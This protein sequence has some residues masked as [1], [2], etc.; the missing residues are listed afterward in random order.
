MSLSALPL[1]VPA[2]SA[3]G[4]RDASI[5]VTPIPA[6]LEVNPGEAGEYVIRVRN[7]GSNPVSV[8]LSTNQEATQEC[9]AYSSAIT[10]I[11][12]QIDAGSY[13]EATLNVTLT[14]SAEGTCDTTVTVNANEQVTPPD[15]AGAPAQETATVTT[16]AGDGSGSAFFG[17]DLTVNSADKEQDWAGEDELTYRVDV[18][19]TGQNNETI[20]LSVEENNDPGCTSNSEFIVT[21]SDTSVSLDSEEVET[22]T[23]TVEIPDGQSADQYCWDITGTVTNDPSSEAKDTD[24]F[25]LVVPELKTCSVELSK[26]SLSVNPGSSSS[27]TATFSNTGNVDWTVTIASTGSKASWVSVDGASSRLLRYDDGQG[28]ISVDLDVAPDDSIDAGSEAVITILGKDGSS[29]DPDCQKQLRV[30]VGQSYGAS[31]SLATTLLN[32]IDPGTNRSTVVTVSNQGNGQDNLRISS[33]SAPSGWAIQLEQ[34]TVLVGSRHGNQDSASVDLTVRVPQDALAIEDVE[35]TLS[36]LPS[37]GGAT[38][39]SVVLRVTV[40]EIHDF[41]VLTPASEQ[42]GR[43]LT[44][45]SFPIEVSNLGNV[46]DRM[47]FSVVDQSES[48][49]WDTAFEDE[50]GMKFTEI[51]L[52]PQTVTLVYLVVS[53]PQGEEL[54]NTLLTVRVRN[55]DDTNTQDLDNN[56]IPDNQREVDFL[57]ILSDRNFAM[58]MRLVDGETDK[59]SSQILPPNGEI[60]YGLWVKNTGDGRDDAVFTMNGLEGIATRSLTLNGLPVDGEI[61]I[62]PGYGI[63]D[64]ANET[65]VLEDGAPLLGD[66]KSIVENMKLNRGLMIGYDAKPY[67]IYFELTIRVSP[68]AETG[69]GG[70]LEVVVT[71]VSNAANRTGMVSLMLDVSIIQDLEFIEAGARQEL[72]LVFGGEAIEHEISIVNTG[73]VQTEIRVFTSENLRGWSVVLNSDDGDCTFEQNELT[74][75]VEEGERLYVNATIRAPYGAEL[76]DTY[77][78]TLSAEPTDTGVLDRQNLQFVVQGEPAEGVLDLAGNTTLQAIG[79][80]AIVVLLLLFLIRRD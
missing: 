11:P 23:A 64:I 72:D 77:K 18:E 49:E 67:E 80:T 56:G 74:C 29:V 47:A 37:T 58:S 54:D 20:A 7:T 44:D 36:V 6:T 2:V 38:Y 22:I 3:D 5:T 55:K 16:T 59:T 35:I 43:S 62:L 51:I 32:G 66:S 70:L 34:S 46:R 41:E 24:D 42:T 60:T 57:A 17:V 50:N 15:V 76:S 25:K 61:E 39:D 45:V 21:L 9:N 69:Q 8:S 78:F 79:A 28:T 63:W 14:Q 73:N 19:N 30:V 4:A 65:Y 26:T 52:D 31:I 53:I 10:Q 12:G 33:T 75:M 48:P 71:S 68:G 13:E 27:L 1:A 40:G